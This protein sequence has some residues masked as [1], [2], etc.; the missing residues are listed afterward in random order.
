MRAF[1]HEVPS[2]PWSGDGL[3][4]ELTAEGEVPDDVWELRLVL[5]RMKASLPMIMSRNFPKYVPSVATSLLDREFVPDKGLKQLILSDAL[6]LVA[7]R[8]LQAKPIN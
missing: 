3:T 5:L 7:Y 1:R 6:A 4:C 2:I 8:H